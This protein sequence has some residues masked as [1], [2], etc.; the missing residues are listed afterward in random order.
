MQ[1]KKQW[2]VQR[3]K[4]GSEKRGTI[5]ST[6]MKSNNKREEGRNNYFNMI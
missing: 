3:G 4:V 1:K 2:Q 5:A 6:K